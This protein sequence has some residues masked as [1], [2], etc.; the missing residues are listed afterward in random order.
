M[1]TSASGTT[2]HLCVLA[3][4]QIAEFTAVVF[5]EPGEDYC[6]GWEI[7]AHGECLCREKDFDQRL[8]KEDFHNLF[9]NG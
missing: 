2:S 6:T 5:A 4:E 3:R 7:E 8:R 9:Y 1:M